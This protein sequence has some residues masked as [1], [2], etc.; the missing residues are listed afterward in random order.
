MNT[1]K[2]INIWWCLWLFNS[3]HFVLFKVDQIFARLS[4][5]S[6]RNS[7]LLKFS[8][9]HLGFQRYK[10]LHFYI[11]DSVWQQCNDL[12]R[13]FQVF[14]LN[15]SDVLFFAVGSKDATQRCVFF[16][17]VHRYKLIHRMSQFNRAYLNG[18]KRFYSDWKIRKSSSQQVNKELY[19][20][21]NPF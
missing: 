8:V 5:Q 17:T 21:Y 7:D 14:I 18:L 6:I 12:C 19:N 10:L 16:F 13:K 3:S 20:K 1:D 11:F 9:Y 2:D 4:L 15:D